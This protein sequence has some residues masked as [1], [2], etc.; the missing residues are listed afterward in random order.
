VFNRTSA[1]GFLTWIVVTNRVYVDSATPL[2]NTT[3]ASVSYLAYTFGNNPR[4]VNMTASQTQYFTMVD[5]TPPTSSANAL[6]TWT[7]TL[8]FSIHY[9]YSDGGGLGVANVTLWY[10]LNSGYWQSYSTQNTTGAS[11]G[12]FGFM[13][14]GDGTY[15][16]VTIAVD[17]AG[18]AEPFPSGNDTWTI[19]D[20]TRP[21][22]HVLALPTYETSLSFTVSWSPDPGVTD[23][24]TYQ[25]QYNAGSGWVT[26]L[27][28]TSATSALFTATG[29][30]VYAFRS[31]AFDHAGNSETPPATNDTWTIVDTLAPASTVQAL[32]A[33]E[34]NLTF[35]VTWGP[36][37]GNTDIASYQVQASDNGG[38]WTS[39]LVATA[40]GSANFNGTDGHRIAFRSLATDLAGNSESKGSGNDTWTS[41]D[42]TPPGSSV[43]SLPRYEA[44]LSFS[45][46]WGPAVGVTDSV[47]FT[48]YVSDNDGT[49]TSVAGLVNTASTSA[50]FAGADGHVYAFRSLAK[51]AAGNTEMK[52]SG[53][54][55]FTFV[56]V[57][58]PLVTADAPEGA[59]TNLTPSITVTFS[60]AMDQVSVQQAFS[61]APS[62]NGNFLWSPDG[63][64]FTFVPARELQRT[65]TY[66]VV[67]DT[68][69][70]DLAGNTM[71]AAKTFNFTTSASVAG[72]GL[73]LGDLW[74]ILA[75]VLAAL[76]G[77]ILFVLYRRRGAEEAAASSPRS[78]PPPAAPAKAQAAIDDVFLLYGRD[79]LLI[80]H[81]T[82]RLR[83]D[84]D[85]DILSGMLT[86][87]QQFVKDSFHGEEGEELNEMT[88]GQMHILIGR[89]KWLILAA[90]VTGGDVDS[91][92]VQIKKCV[93]D[94]ED[95]NWDR[96]EDWD[97]DM[98][99]AK[100]LTPYVRKLI[101]NEYA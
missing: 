42:V 4:T 12:Q 33:Y 59:G 52:A 76:V 21:A 9:T 5:S 100:A 82:R 88:V 75:V 11:T 15:E 13:A 71:S 60:E 72:G 63:R 97:G 62:I 10:R 38:P 99:L 32:P 101:R 61:I 48:I 92:S 22:S 26:W 73:A 94:M 65:T 45:I 6:P 35:S 46:S 30:G 27:G 17:R 69:A 49:W 44:S 86:A 23:I 90:T 1:S 96:L 39:W 84:I 7:N 18:N 83:P 34:T 68:S 8:S 87:V 85:T 54:D 79:G 89:G 31:T 56:D 20:T 64:S 81:E 14:A 55:T 53:N 95:H 67:I 40:G 51:D 25:I 57:T 43:V 19:V 24:L 28:D 41:V 77:G 29:Q 36:M 2:W 47:S 91:M 80:K 3:Q 50:T 16:F 58:R 66:V 98:E 74:P 70:K 37:L 93:E 78:A